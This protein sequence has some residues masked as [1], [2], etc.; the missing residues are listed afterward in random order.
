MSLKIINISKE[1]NGKTVLNNFSAV[2]EPKGMTAFF[3]G[4]GCGKTTLLKIIMGLITPDSGLVE[5][6]DGLK[7]AAVFQE[8][9]LLEWATAADNVMFVMKKK[10]KKKA[11]E[12]LELML[13]DEA[14]A[15]RASELSGG[16]KRRLALA[17]ALAV[18]SDLL[19]LDEPFSGLDDKTKAHVMNIIKRYGQKQTVIFVSHDINE[20]QFFNCKIYDMN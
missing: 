4:S 17:R 8:D 12:L 6:I 18:T 13:I 10:D 5:G 19:I 2:I 16:M 7:L 1:F 15:K 20:L 11:L 3:G 14:A 9:R